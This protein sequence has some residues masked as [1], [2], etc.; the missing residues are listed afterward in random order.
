[1]DEHAKERDP[2]DDPNFDRA[3]IADE[4][5]IAGDPEDVVEQMGD[6]DLNLHNGLESGLDIRGVE[7][8]RKPRGGS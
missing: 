1:M 3:D 2:A 8:V 5:F 6:H 7:N 4:N